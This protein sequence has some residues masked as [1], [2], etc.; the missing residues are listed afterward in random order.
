MSIRTMLPSKARVGDTIHFAFPNSPGQKISGFE[1]TINGQQM[2]E[3]EVL[4]SRANSKDA[5][6]FVYRVM[7]PGIYQFRIT[8]I[9]QDG[10]RGDPRLNTLE[11]TA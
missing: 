2:P 9:G 8:P 5:T 3:P 11:V 10:G 1:V 4:A 7:Q 6:I